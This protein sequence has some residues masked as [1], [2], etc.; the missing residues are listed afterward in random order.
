MTIEST[1]S[2]IKPS[3][4]AKNIIGVIY[5]RFEAAK[6]QIIAAKMI[7]FTFKEAEGFYIEHKVRP[8]FNTLIDYMISGPIMVQVLQGKNA[9]RRHREIIGETNPTCALSGTLRSDYGENCTKNVVHGSDS[10]KSAKRE[11]E[12]FF[13]KNTIHPRNY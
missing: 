9:V 4:I 1:C 7:H 10:I 6:L 5:A 8:F 3:A 2:I 13:A 12:Y 11:I